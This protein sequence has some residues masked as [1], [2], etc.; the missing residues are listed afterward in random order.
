MKKTLL[1]LAIAAVST[2]AFAVETS[3]QNSKPMFEFEDMHKDQFSV[4]GAWGVGGYYDSYSGAIYD[5]WATALTLAV[6]Y[7]NNRWVGYFETDLMVNY[8]SDT[9]DFAKVKETY[10]AIE[11]GPNT[12]VD[13][14]WLGFD[15][16]FG[17]ASFG[18]ENDTAL[19]KVDGAGDMTYEFGASAGD[20]SDAYNVVK[21]QG[22]TSGFAYGVSYFETDES[23]AAADK[24]VNGYVGFEHEI[25]NIYAGYE[26][27]DEADYTVTSVSGNV[28]IGDTVK[29]GF[30]SWIDDGEK[31]SSKLNLLNKKKTGYYLSGAF[32]ASEQ[33][34]VAA[35]YGAN[36]TEQDRLADEDYSYMNV[37]VMYT[38]SDRLDMGIDIKQE[39]DV[40]DGVRT[41]SSDEETFVFAAAY[42]YF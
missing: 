39:L 4:S 8:I 1:A 14:A 11:S 3:S 2:S 6:S 19:D 41:D 20:A 30:N 18:W 7:K 9:N 35:G 31:D 13:K 32:D 12:D 40:F 17:V 24:G 21:F 34:T 15:T 25:F 16:G 10:G 33:V 5:D 28:K 26:D 38:H 37:A 36:T 23:H 22:A 29:L 27:R 42:Y